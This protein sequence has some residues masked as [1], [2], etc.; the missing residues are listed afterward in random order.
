MAE[1]R[2]TITLGPSGQV[3]NRGGSKRFTGSDGFLSVNRRSRL[4]RNKWRHDAKTGSRIAQN[5]LRLKLM[6]KRRVEEQRKRGLQEKKANAFRLRHHPQAKGTHRLRQYPPQDILDDFHPEDSF[7]SQTMDRSRATSPGR[8]WTAV[9]FSPPGGFN[10]LQQVPAIRVA[11]FSRAGQFV[12]NEVGASRQTAHMAAQ[13]SYPLAR[14]GGFMRKG[15]LMGVEHLT[16]AEVLESLALRKYAIIFQAE[17][18]DMH[19][20]KQMSDKDLKELGIPMG[21]RRK[22]LRAVKFRP[23]QSWP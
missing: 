13:M 21:P 18:I 14:S 1:P 23:K 5:D 19:A 4:D 9:G 20:L 11:E 6:W 7:S 16:V 22:I 2:V 17:E 10:V 8:S 12:S 3:V 15:A